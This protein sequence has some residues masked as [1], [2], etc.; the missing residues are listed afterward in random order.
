M[1]NVAPEEVAKSTLS[2]SLTPPVTRRPPSVRSSPLAKVE[3]AL[4]LIQFAVGDVHN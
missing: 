1:V 4:L 2:N 3:V